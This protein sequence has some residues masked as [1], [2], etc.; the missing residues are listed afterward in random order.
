MVKKGWFAKISTGD[1]RLDVR[2]WPNAHEERKEVNTSAEAMSPGG[3]PD[4]MSSA[5]PAQLC[6]QPTRDSRERGEKW[7][8]G[9]AKLFVYLPDQQQDPEGQDHSLLI[10]WASHDQHKARW[11]KTTVLRWLWE[12]QSAVSH[13]SSRGRR[14]GRQNSAW[15]PSKSPIPCDCHLTRASASI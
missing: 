10:P 2:N 8:K 6:H 12:G 14:W 4:W 5:C 15:N 7:H 11:K 9:L 1:P 13:D 3:W